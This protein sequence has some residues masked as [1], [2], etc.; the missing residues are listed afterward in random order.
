MTTRHWCTCGRKRIVHGNIFQNKKPVFF[1]LGC[2]KYWTR[3]NGVFHR[4]KPSDRTKESTKWLRQA[5]QKAIL[6]G[7]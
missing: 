2:R 4:I 1:C 6:F 7:G 5:R 3:E